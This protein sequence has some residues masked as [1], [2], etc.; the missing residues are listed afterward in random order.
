VKE[1]APRGESS[2]G[3]HVANSRLKFVALG[4][5]AGRERTTILRLTELL[6]DLFI[7]PSAMDIVR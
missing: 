7:K 6:W 3:R 1:D 5:P 4:A 2:K